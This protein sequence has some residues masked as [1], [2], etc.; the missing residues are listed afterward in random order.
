MAV[1]ETRAAACAWL[2]VNFHDH[3]RTFYFDACGF[4][5]TDADLIAL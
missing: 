2:H 4:S 3:L 1:R 5:L